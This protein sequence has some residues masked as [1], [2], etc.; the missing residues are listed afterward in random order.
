MMLWGLGGFTTEYGIPPD[1]MAR[2]VETRGFES[3][4]ISEH[5]HMPVSC[6]DRFPRD[7][8]WCY[9]PFMALAVMASATEK[10]ILATGIAQVMQR[11]PI[12]TAKQVATLDRLSDGRFIFGI[13]AGGNL[14]EEIENHGTNYKT[15]FSLLRDRVKAMKAI[16]TEE[17]AEHHGR[18]VDFG[19][20][21][22]Y[23]KPIQKPH[24]PVHMGGGTG[25]RVM[26]CLLDVCDGWL[27]IGSFDIWPGVK[28]AIKELPDRAAEIGRSFESIEISMFFFEVPPPDLVEDMQA[29]GVKRVIVDFPCQDRDSALQELDNIVKATTG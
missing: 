3:L 15:R 4:W 1:E 14:R 6:A 8:A 7:Y 20:I 12:E 24:P 16:W 21:I 17:H 9:D 26:K 22:S 11:D 10:L 2:E 29:S 27:P 25:P 19:P 5:L 23:P 18:F 13:G 28:S